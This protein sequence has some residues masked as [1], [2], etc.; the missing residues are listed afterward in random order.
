MQSHAVRS[1]HPEAVSPSPLHAAPSASGASVQRGLNLRRPGADRSSVS[2]GSGLAAV[3]RRSSAVLGFAVL[4]VSGMALPVPDVL[5]DTRRAT[6]VEILERPELFIE[7]RQ[8]HVKDVATEPETLTTQQCRA[9]LLVAGG[10]TARMT[11]N[12]LLRLGGQ[13]LLLDRGSVL[14]SGPESG[15]TRSVRLSPRGTNYILEVLDNGD[16]A[17]TSLE[18]TLQV[19]LLEDGRPTSKPPVTLSSGQRLRLYEALG[20][21][22]VIDLTPADYR[23]I[24]EGPLFRGFRERLADQSL[25]ETHLQTNVPGVSLPAPEPE[26]TAGPGLPMQLLFQFVPGG[27]GSHS[28]PKPS[29]PERHHHHPEPQFQRYR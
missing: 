12:T 11:R 20:L 27:G 2:C 22:T 5:A 1:P 10:A 24:F 25:L 9:Q 8:A 21:T 14:I 6:V 13:C 17:V 7:R 23:G 19:E 16:T 18:G 29:R 3:A 4:F 26:P 15:C 28:T